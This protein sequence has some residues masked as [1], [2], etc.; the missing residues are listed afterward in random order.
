MIYD[1]AC[2]CYWMRFGF[3]ILM[4]EYMILLYVHGK[5]VVLYV[6]MVILTFD[7]MYFYHLH[8]IQLYLY[9]CD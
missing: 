5:Q 9:N 3:I 2:L 8:G 7:T 4:K 6:S 1:S